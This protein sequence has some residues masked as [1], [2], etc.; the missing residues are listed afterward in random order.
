MDWV[1]ALLLFPHIGGAILAFGPTS[2]FMIL[3]PM[4]GRE[5]MHSNFALRFQK[6][7][8]TTLIAPLAVL[9]GVTGLLIV[10]R[11]GWDIL[12]NGWLLAAIALYLVLLA[13]GFGVLF[14]TLGRL[15]EA[16]ATPPPAPAP[17]A[18]AP[19]GPPPH[20]RALA[21]RARLAGTVNAVLIVVIVFLM[22]TKPF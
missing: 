7:V 13:I 9:Q 19:S 11:A 18:A 21:S 17:G 16:T 4:V 22:V 20:I 14:P 6:R 8:S 12:A 15:L 1:L 5:P 2:A 10:W 3:G